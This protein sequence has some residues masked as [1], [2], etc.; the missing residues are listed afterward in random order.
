MYD[1]TVTTT[2]VMHVPISFKG[3]HCEAEVG[4]RS[5]ENPGAKGNEQIQG[6]GWEGQVHRGNHGELNVTSVCQLNCC[7][8]S[9][10]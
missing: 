8:I 4:Q 5:Q 2:S 1:V 7:S 10:L 3:C 9:F 6:F